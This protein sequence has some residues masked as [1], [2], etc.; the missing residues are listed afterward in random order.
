MDQPITRVWDLKKGFTAVQGMFLEL[1]NAY[2][3]VNSVF[4]PAIDVLR[5]LQN[6]F[7]PWHG[8]SYDGSHRKAS[9]H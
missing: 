2:G 7:G 5:K 9:M 3:T 1:G 8:Q 4:G 6:D